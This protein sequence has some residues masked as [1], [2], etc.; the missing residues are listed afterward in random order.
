[1]HKIVLRE[2]KF[3]CVCTKVQ[4]LSA[5]SGHECIKRVHVCALRHRRLFIAPPKV[6]GQAQ[7]LI[8]V[9]HH[10]HHRHFHHHYH[11]EVMIIVI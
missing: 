2:C 6:G 10:H 4:H 8:S 11:Q 1:M 9:S 3:V 7:V 5:N